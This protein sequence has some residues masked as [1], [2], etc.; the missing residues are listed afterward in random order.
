M[1][2]DAL[3]PGER[4]LHFEVV[5][6][7]GR[8]GMG[9]VYEARDTK[10]RRR[11][12]LKVLPS[13]VAGDPERRERFLREA[14]AAAAV[15]HPNL[16]VVFEI[17]ESEARLFIA[18]E[19]VEGE[20]LRAHLARHAAGL[21]PDEAV[22][23]A[24]AIA[25]G[26][27]RAHRAGVVHRDLKPENVM[28]APDGVKLL[29]F[30]IAKA[31]EPVDA[32]AAHAEHATVTGSG[33]A[34]THE[35]AMIGTPGYM[36][37]EQ[38]S[39]KA[40]DRRADVF[41]LGVVLYELLTG[42]APFGGA[43]PMERAVATLRD[44]PALPSS[45][46]TG[47][48]RSLDSL[49]T[50]CLAKR[51]DERFDDAGELFAALD[52]LDAGEVQSP[53]ARATPERAPAAD[54]LA[55]TEPGSSPSHATDAAASARSLEQPRPPAKRSPWIIAAIPAL[56]V[57][58]VAVAFRSG[59]SDSATGTVSAAASASAAPSAAAAARASAGA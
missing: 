25:A 1:S 52:G 32:A 30:G 2:L 54:P 58:A 36:A 8:G 48:P 26:L 19:F 57:A 39:G 41:A 50:R 11:V 6:E 37:P 47:I 56:L 43:T 55:P 22:R 51:A 28:I 27:A 59:R 13:A 23:I 45:L 34:L 42:R 9:V 38:V 31:L 5:R 53:A 33:A 44:E 35:G 18:M 3:Q 17:G 40:S 29:D 15:T 21:P 49:V 24:S 12:A 46:A 14:R 7:L 20:S 16:V 4:L 10:L